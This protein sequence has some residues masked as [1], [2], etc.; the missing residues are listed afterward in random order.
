MYP[1]SCELRG[2]CKVYKVE[3]SEVCAQ[4]AGFRVWGSG[5]RPGGVVPWVQSLA[6]VCILVNSAEV[7]FCLM[8]LVCAFNLRMFSSCGGLS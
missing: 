6:T 2:S 4:D 5:L 3:G 1:G 8:I 7:D